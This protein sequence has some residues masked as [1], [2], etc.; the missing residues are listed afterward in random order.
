MDEAEL[1]NISLEGYEHGP[2]SLNF[3]LDNV[4]AGM[5]LLG[6][7]SDGHQVIGGFSGSLLGTSEQVAFDP[8][9]DLPMPSCYRSDIENAAI[10]LL[11]GESEPQYTCQVCNSFFCVSE[12]PLRVRSS[13]PSAPIG[14]FESILMRSSS[15][16]ISTS[17]HIQL[18]TIAF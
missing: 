18:M 5:D 13:N 1:W 15:H 12:D 8:I 7:S 9:L 2:G 11:E 6:V 17:L 4:G 16:L 14:R 3:F 10:Q